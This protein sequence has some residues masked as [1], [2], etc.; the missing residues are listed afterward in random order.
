M[1]QYLVFCLVLLLAGILAAGCTASSP[2]SQ[3][4]VTGTPAA[5]QATVTVTTSSA[6]AQPTLALGD[7]YLQ[8]SYSFHNTNDKYTEQVRI[9]DPSWALV[10]TVTPLSDD[11]QSDWFELTITNVDSKK[12]QTF[13]YGR[14]YAYDT[15]QQYP[16]YAA[17]SYEIDM[18][19][20]LT[21]IDLDVAKRL[22]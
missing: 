9:A 11:V 7:H 10:Y 4:P 16:M 18:K 21:K 20:N 8:K 1:K 17:G 15:F 14:T 13:G 19:G 6:S 22:P 12:S 5:T 3:T 2:S